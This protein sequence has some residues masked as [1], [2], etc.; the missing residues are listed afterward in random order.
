MS[1][2]ERPRDH[3]AA[4]FV[5]TLPRRIL[6]SGSDACLPPVTLSVCLS[7][8]G[9]S[10]GPFPETESPGACRAL[11]WGKNRAGTSDTAWRDLSFSL[12]SSLGTVLCQGPSFHIVEFHPLFF[13]SCFGGN[14][15]GQGRRTP[16]LSS[17]TWKS[18][19]LS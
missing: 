19:F 8:A 17:A 12:F 10:Q 15:G 1:S 11:Q 18:P 16:L 2:G 9:E 4:V 3:S 14:V 7:S 13:L 6:A 5:N